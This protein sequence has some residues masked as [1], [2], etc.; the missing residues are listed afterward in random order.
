MPDNA[1][2]LE[3]TVEESDYRKDESSRADIPATHGHDHE[4]KK[5]HICPKRGSCNIN[6]TTTAR[7]RGNGCGESIE[8]HKRVYTNKIISRVQTAVE[9]P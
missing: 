5:W 4:E 6:A 3:N 8:M 9:T 2:E 1:E 7:V